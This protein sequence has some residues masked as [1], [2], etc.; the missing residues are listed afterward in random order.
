MGGAGGSARRIAGAVSVGLVVGAIGLLAGSQLGASHARPVMATA[1]AVAPPTTLVTLTTV[2]TPVTVAAPAP[3]PVV[4]LAA[5]ERP[6]IVTVPVRQPADIGRE[7]LAMIDFPWQQRLNLTIEFAGARSGMRATSTA[8]EDHD[9]ITVYVRPTDSIQ[10]TAVN[11]AHELG[12]LIDF[13]LRSD[14]ERAEWLQERGRPNASWWTCN[15]CSDYAYGSGDFAET[16]AAWE[17]GPLDYRS[18]LAPLPAG[19]QMNRLAH[20]FN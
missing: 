11:I 1:A 6:A 3:E 7:A 19:D 16:F 5:K 12:H 13:R 8:Y 15:Y 14:A 17:V 4:Q 18:T 10:M 9:V 20:F 2:A